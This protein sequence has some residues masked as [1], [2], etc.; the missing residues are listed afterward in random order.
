[1]RKDL[2]RR[3]AQLE[4]RSRPREPGPPFVVVVNSLE[5]ER[6][7]QLAAGERIVQDWFR[8][9]H[10]YVLARER[11]TSQ[12]DDRGRRCAWNSYLEDVIRELHQQC[13]HRDRGCQ[14]CEG[15]GLFP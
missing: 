3:M 8:N 14:L 4:Q 15:L 11:I 5:A 13:E 12:A 1:M 9:D 6:R 10:Q 7:N 2:L